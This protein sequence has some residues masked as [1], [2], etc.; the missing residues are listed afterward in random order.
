MDRPTRKA[1]R[2]SLT[3]KRIKNTRYWH[4]HLSILLAFRAQQRAIWGFAKPDDLRDHFMYP[5]KQLNR[6]KKLS[7]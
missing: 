5:Y 6:E 1:V 7:R 2:R 4:A 3:R